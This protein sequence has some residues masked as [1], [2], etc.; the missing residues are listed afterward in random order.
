MTRAGGYACIFDPG[1]VRTEWDTHTCAHCNTVIHMRN[2]KLDD[3]GGLC[4]QC[5]K[6][7]CRG[8]LDNGCTPFER[9]LEMMEARDR[10]RRSLIYGG[11]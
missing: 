9:K 10:F 3:I 4:R 7:I 5:M 2:K 11:S 8:C 6:P 1:G